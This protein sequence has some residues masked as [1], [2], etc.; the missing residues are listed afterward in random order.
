MTRKIY[1]L[2]DPSK[3]DKTGQE[4]SKQDIIYLGEHSE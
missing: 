4:Q 2:A 3:F 1:I